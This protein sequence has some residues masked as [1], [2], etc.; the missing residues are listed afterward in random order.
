MEENIISDHMD[1][2]NQRHI[3]TSNTNFSPKNH[4]SKKK[5]TGRMQK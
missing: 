1:Y 4:I 5:K 2:R 3:Y